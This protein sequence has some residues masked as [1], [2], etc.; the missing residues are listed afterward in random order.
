MAAPFLFSIS[1]YSVGP[2]FAC[3][4][5]VMH[6]SV[7]AVLMFLLHALCHCFLAAALMYLARA[8]LM[9][10]NRDQSPT[11]FLTIL[12]RVDQQVVIGRLEPCQPARQPCQPI[13][14][15]LSTLS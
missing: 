3:F 15:P 1:L 9:A 10:R 2:V 13:C 7:A 6:R 11:Q 14:Q 4:P 12:L 5:F 8:D